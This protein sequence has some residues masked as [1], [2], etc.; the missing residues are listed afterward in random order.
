MTTRGLLPFIGPMAPFLDPGSMV[1]E[2][3]GRYGYTLGA[4]TLAEHR[5]L[6]TQAVVEAHP[7]LHT[8]RHDT[9]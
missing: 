4:R 2:D 5:R 7:Q 1:F 9:R 3:P 6:L 8:G